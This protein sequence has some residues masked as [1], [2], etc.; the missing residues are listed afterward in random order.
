MSIYSIDEVN[1]NK[2]KTDWGEVGNAAITNLINKIDSTNTIS[3]NDILSLEELLEAKVVTESLPLNQF[4]NEP[5]HIGAAGVKQQLM[6]VVSKIKIN[7]ILTINHVN[8]EMSKAL[9]KL[10]NLRDIISSTNQIDYLSLRN[11]NKFMAYDDNDKLINLLDVNITEVFMGYYRQTKGIFGGISEEISN[12]LDGNNTIKL[13]PL[14]SGLKQRVIL[15]SHT[16]RLM[17]EEF[18]IND[19][20]NIYENRNSV[21]DL[22]TKT[23]N[24]IRTIM[25]DSTNPK[26]SYY[27]DTDDLKYTHK[28]YH[29]LNSML[30]DELSMYILKYL[31]LNRPIYND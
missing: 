8:K 2:P 6:D 27:Y 4:T 3:K 19:L 7:D 30:D 13:T 24:G 26:Y 9:S 21:L 16:D 29:E 10:L 11:S 22:I 18:T 31:F 5:S 14:L 15:Q 25:T 12:M 17:L 28:Q 23:I 20:I 1:D